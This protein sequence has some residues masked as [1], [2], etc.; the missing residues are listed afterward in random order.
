MKTLKKMLTHFAAHLQY[1]QANA[2]K[3]NIAKELQTLAATS[4]RITINFVANFINKIKPNNLYPP[5][6]QFLFYNHSLFYLSK[7]LIFTSEHPPS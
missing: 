6:T 4:S 2:A 1:I 3:A 7:Q 5:T